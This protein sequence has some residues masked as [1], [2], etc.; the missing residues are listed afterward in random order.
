MD[1][2]TAK[3]KYREH[4]KRCTEGKLDKAGNP[5]E[6]RLTFEQWCDIWVDSGKWGQ[7][8]NRRGQYVMARKGDIGHYEVGNVSIIL[9]SENNSEAHSGKVVRHTEEAKAKISAGLTG[10]PVSDETREKI[11]KA[12]TGHVT[13]EDTKRKLSELNKGKPMRRVK[14]E[15]CG[16]E[17]SPQNLSRHKRVCPK[18]A[19]REPV[20]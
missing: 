13:A 20:S 15:D 11:R 5:V 18:S 16:L 1:Y 3:V 9:H 14:C 19:Q 7:R 4:T 2:R 6:M 10:R 17:T 8:G 12:N